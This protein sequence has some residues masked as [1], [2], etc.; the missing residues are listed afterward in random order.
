[1]M[2]IFFQ[3]WTRDELLKVASSCERAENSRWGALPLIMLLWY[4]ALENRKS[5]MYS[6]VDSNWLIIKSILHKFRLKEKIAYITSSA[7]TQARKSL[8]STP[9]YELHEIATTKH[10]EKHSEII[11]YKGLNLYVIDGSNLNLPSCESLSEAFGRPYSSS[12]TKKSLPQA[13]FT[14]L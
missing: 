4:W 10:F 3:V 7:L 13:S 14:A 11:K 6:M 5:K 9:F 12:S 2:V 1:M 8:G